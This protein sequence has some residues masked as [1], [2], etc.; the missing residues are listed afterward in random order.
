MIK[1]ESR[2]GWGNPEFMG[3]F[4]VEGGEER[5]P[6][7]GPDGNLYFIADRLPSL[8]RGDLFVSHCINEDW[9][10]WSAPENLGKEINTLGDEKHWLSIAP[11]NANAVFATDEL[12]KNNESHLYA[13]ALPSVAKAEKRNILTLAV[14]SLGQNL[15]P[16]QRRELIL[17]VKD[18]TSNQLLTEVKPQGE[19]RFIVS[20]PAS[21]KKIRY[22][23]MESPKN[24]VPITKAGEYV[25]NPE[26]VQELPGLPSN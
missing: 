1:G 25:L 20:L 8:G 2:F 18:A 17:Q 9:K 7:F 4:V 22:Q 10:E 19:K 16:S 11:D 13:N 23:V 14:G 5:A 15:S 21:V 12:S 26:N 6:C 3:S 24:P